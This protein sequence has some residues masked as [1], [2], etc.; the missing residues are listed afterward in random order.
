MRIGAGHGLSVMGVRFMLAL[1]GIDMALLLPGEKET[2]DAASE[3]RQIL[4]ELGAQPFIER[5]DA[6]LGAAALSSIAAKDSAA[7][8]V[9]PAAAG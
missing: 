3:A 2:A 8:T 9:A 5:L 6:L 1:T 4:V 7:R